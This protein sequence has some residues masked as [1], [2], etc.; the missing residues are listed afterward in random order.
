MK[1]IGTVVVLLF[2]LIVWLPLAGGQVVQPGIP[3]FVSIVPQAFFLERL[4][5]NRVDVTV[6]IGEGQSP[7]SYEPT[8]K[9]MAKLAAARAFFSIGVPAEKGVMRKIRQIHRNLLIVETHR[10]VPFRYLDER[11]DDHGQGHEKRSAVQGGKEPDPHIWMDP[12]LVKIQARNIQMAL[13]QL[14]PLH[15]QE[16]EANLKAFLADLDRV[17]ARIARSLA[18]FRGGRMYVYHPAFGYFAEAYGLKQIPIEVEGKQPSARQ[19]ADLI[20]RAKRDKVKVMFVQPQFSRKGAEIIAKA[21][22]GVV[23]PINPLAPDYLENME[24]IAIEVEKGLR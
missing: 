1:K 18:P 23:V 2:V 12:K 15:R 3:V 7:H 22:G 24:K 20:D 14:D 17:D 8:P 16:Y 19:L 5:G 6:L 4:G 13:Q 10:G 9:Q 21:I 11:H